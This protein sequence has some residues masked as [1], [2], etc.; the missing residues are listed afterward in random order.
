MSE[1]KVDYI[2]QDAMFC[3]SSKETHPCTAHEGKKWKRRGKGPI[4]QNGLL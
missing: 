3:N 1:H 2:F 4:H